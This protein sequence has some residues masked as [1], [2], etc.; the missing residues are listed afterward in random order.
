MAT[1]HKGEIYDYLDPSVK[2]IRLFIV[3][4]QTADESVIEGRLMT[5]PLEKMKHAFAL[6]YCWGPPEDGMVNII[7]QG[8]CL[9]VPRNL[10]DAL[11]HIGRYIRT[12]RKE[13]KHMAIW[14]DAV[15][16]HQADKA[17]KTSQIRHMRYIFENAKCVISWLGLAW[18]GGVIFSSLVQGLGRIPLEDDQAQ[19]AVFGRLDQ[20]DFLRNA[21]SDVKA[22]GE[23]EMSFRHFFAR[24]NWSRVW[25][26][27]ENVLPK[28]LLQCFGD[29]VI[30][31]AII[32]N[33]FLIIGKFFELPWEER[34]FSKGSFWDVLYNNYFLLVRDEAATFGLVFR[35]RLQWHRLSE[36]VRWTE[37]GLKTVL[38]CRNLQATN[39]RDRIYGTLGLVQS[40]VPVD[41]SKTTSTVFE[42][43]TVQWFHEMK[44]LDI[45]AVA[46]LSAYLMN[47]DG[48]VVDVYQNIRRDEGSNSDCGAEDGSSGGVDAAHFEAKANER[49]SWV[50]PEQE[51]LLPPLYSDQA[52]FRAS[53]DT[54]MQLSVLEAIKALKVHG[55][56]C[57]NIAEVAGPINIFKDLD[58]AV[59]MMDFLTIALPGGKKGFEAFTRLILLDKNPETACRLRTEMSQEREVVM[60]LLR[61]IISEYN[62][63]EMITL[64]DSFVRKLIERAMS[65]FVGETE[66]ALVASLNGDT[67]IAFTA[68]RQFWN[69]M[70][71]EVKMSGMR[72]VLVRLINGRVGR[73]AMAP[74]GVRN[75]D[76]V[77]VLHGC[78]YP[79]LLRPSADC[80]RLMGPCYVLGLMDGEILQ[81]ASV[82]VSEIQ[83]L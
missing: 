62:E 5:I 56:C 81:D 25:I 75:D 14:A 19:R 23:I 42:D 34:P 8:R 65:I 48:E 26:L 13:E 24:T 9:P 61:L 66:E 80:Y 7:V 37:F 69:S 21:T 53:G 33:F 6:S 3:D 40:H 60:S 51:S 4:L 73:L 83:I 63:V 10:K 35:K 16:I 64:S 20:E 38:S 30:D 70:V 72:S 52:I 28:Y 29:Y 18:K 45:L 54:E 43:F 31:A 57:G 59:K 17:E 76:V 44:N 77:Y 15:C 11:Q 36:S 50:F 47:R 46:G 41:Y 27:E 78:N 82:E 1:S 67:G 22:T 12:N 55:R 79:L 32:W 58:T 68:A 71:K 2:Q 74:V 49:P 39:P